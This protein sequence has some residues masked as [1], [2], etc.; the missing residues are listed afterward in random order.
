[1]L[2]AAFELQKKQIC[3]RKL[4]KKETYTKVHYSSL[5]AATTVAF[6]LFKVHLLFV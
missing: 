2:V 5:P 1:M 4:Y 3:T 6:L